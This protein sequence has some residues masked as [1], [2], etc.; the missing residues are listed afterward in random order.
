MSK[1]SRLNSRGQGIPHVIILAAGYATRLYPLTLD[2]PKPLLTVSGRPIIEHIIERLHP[3]TKQIYMVINDK[4]ADHFSNWREN[5]KLPFAAD[6]SLVNDGSV[7]ES[8]KLGAIG[9]IHFVLNKHSIDRDLLVVAGD[10]IF[11]EELDEFYTV[12]KRRGTPVVGLYDVG[13]LEEAKK[14][15]NVEVDEEGKLL[16]FIEKPPEPKTS[17]IAIALYYYPKECIPY[18][19]QYVEEGNNPDQPGRLIQWLYERVPVYTW[20][21][22][23]VWFDIGTKETLQAAERHFSAS[24]RPKIDWNSPQ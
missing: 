6:I 1:K 23:G 20:R 9:D 18:I 3:E 22:P 24:K 21:L 7:N 10:N 19:K 17:L 12:A 11:S 5:Y 14:F 4:F 8:D 2:R 15:G 16:K 13:S